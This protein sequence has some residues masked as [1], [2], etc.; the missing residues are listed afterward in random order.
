ML[1]IAASKGLQEWF[2]PGKPLLIIRYHS[3]QLS[4]LIPLVDCIVF[5]QPKM[6]VT[7]LVSKGFKEKSV[8]KY[9]KKSLKKSQYPTSLI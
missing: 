4:K 7:D 8:D 5:C 6:T 1:S 2:A 9:I 3:F